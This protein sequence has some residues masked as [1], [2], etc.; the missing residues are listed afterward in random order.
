MKGK[1]KKFIKTKPDDSCRTRE[2][3]KFGEKELGN[4]SIVEYFK[5]SIILSANENIDKLTQRLIRS[6]KYF[7]TEKSSG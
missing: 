1:K 3:Q 6:L 4:V 5:V 2:S 7:C